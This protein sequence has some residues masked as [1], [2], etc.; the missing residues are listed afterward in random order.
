MRKNKIDI[1][2]LQEVELLHE[3]DLSLLEIAGYT[4]EVEKSNGKRRSMIYISNTIQ[5]Q[6]HQE[7]E[8]ENSHV[9]LISITQNNKTIQLASIYRAFK[10]SSNKTHKEEFADQLKVIKGF[11]ENEKASLIIGD[12]NLDY[13][14]KGL[15]SYNH[16][17]MFTQLD[18]LENEMNLSQLVNFN[19]WRRIVN[20]ELR[21]SL[22]D[23][24]Y[25]NVHGL[26]EN[27]SAISTSTSDHTPLLIEVAIKICHKVETKIVRDWSTYS[28]ERLLDLLSKERWD[29]DC[30]DVQDF[31][32]ELEQKIM[33][34]LESLIPFKE[35][36]VRNNNYSEPMWLADMKRKRKNLFKNAR[37]RESTKLFERCHSRLNF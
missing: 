19:T 34:V 30:I 28:K 18:E 36:K 9:I 14:K 12:L 24:V 31:N 8:Q 3:D 5:Y 29:I 20:G 16:H 7:K 32:N 10:L 37:R 4:M 23:H 6:R 35:I 26:V 22:L 1:I 2:C 33:S 27:I 15:L 11:I 25:E 21:T 13:N 17:A